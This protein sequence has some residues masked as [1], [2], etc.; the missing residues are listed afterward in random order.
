MLCSSLT[1]SGSGSMPSASRAAATLELFSGLIFTARF[2]V[3]TH[4]QPL[5]VFIGSVVGSLLFQ[6]F[7]ARLMIVFGSVKSGDLVAVL[8][9]KRP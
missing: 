8:R 5:N 2:G 3:S 7:D 1:V 6:N 9:N 4:Q